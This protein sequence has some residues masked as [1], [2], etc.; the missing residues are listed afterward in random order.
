MD[1][2]KAAPVIAAAFRCRRHK[3]DSSGRL[4]RY[5]IIG[6]IG[7]DMQPFPPKGQAGKVGRWAAQL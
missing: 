2:T 6:K 4:N 1:F 3:A 7:R 5:G